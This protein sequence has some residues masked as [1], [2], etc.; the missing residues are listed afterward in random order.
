MFKFLKDWFG[1]SAS[2]GGAK[3]VRGE[4]VEYNGYRIT[5]TPLVEGGQFRVSGEIESVAD[6]EKKHSFI[7]SDLVA[8]QDEACDF[9]VLKA[10]LMIDQLGD[11]L[12]DR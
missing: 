9:T 8:G 4:T 1:G 10:R 6:P 5:P 11:S 3:Q 12:F 7:R 2:A